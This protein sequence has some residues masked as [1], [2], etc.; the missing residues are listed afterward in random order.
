[1]DHKAFKKIVRNYYH[2]NGR[3]N[4]P[5]RLNTSPY[6]IFVSEVML[7][8][9]QVDRVVPKYT[10]FMTALPSWHALS[11]ASTQQV[12]TLWQGLGYNRRAL[13]LHEAAK[14]IVSDYSGRLPNNFEQLNSLKGIGPNTAGSTMAFAFNEPVI[15]IETNIRRV[16]IYH[17]FADFQVVADDDISSL[18]G[19]TLDRTN[20]R[21]WYWAL[22]DYGTYLAKTITNPN[23][24][25]KHYTKQSKF[26]GSLRQVRGMVLKRL[27]DST[28]TPNELHKD[29]HDARLDQVVKQLQ[30]EGFIRQK[31]EYLE[32]VG[33]K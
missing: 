21:E 17:F 6:S 13:W 22:M 11:S 31:G 19:A 2:S 4:L 29:I 15:F 32:V 14:R 28:A 16:Y 27:L 26:E 23:K 20:P 9:T 5:W 7:Q 30:T 18:V 1:M 24:R 12:L 33:Q 25:S 8:Q 10:E 3:H